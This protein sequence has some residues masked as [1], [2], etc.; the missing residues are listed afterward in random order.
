[1]ALFSP[2]FVREEAVYLL[3]K[4]VDNDRNRLIQ[5]E[6]QGATHAKEPLV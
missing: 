6:L 2:I 1:M 5:S 4:R 3:I